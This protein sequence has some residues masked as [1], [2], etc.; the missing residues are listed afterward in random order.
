MSTM[1]IKPDFT[2]VQVAD[3]YL[4]V[5]VNDQMERFNGTVV[6][7]EVSAFLLEKLKTERSAEEL[8]SL[9]TDEFDV[10]AETAKADVLALIDKMRE[11]GIIDE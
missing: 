11:T 2:I 4:L 10:D 1:K 5:P 9:L 7:N 8:A 3:D 6:L